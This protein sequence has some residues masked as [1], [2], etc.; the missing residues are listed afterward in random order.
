MKRLLLNYIVFILLISQVWG[1]DP[2]YSQFF[3]APQLL[4]PATTGSASSDWRIMSNYRQQWDNA[5]TPFSTFSLT[6]ETKL[7]GKEKGENT[8]GSS[9]TLMADRS[10]YGAFKSVY[11]SGAI[12]YHVQLAVKHR[13]G[14]GI[15]ASYGN[16]RID[17]SQLTFGTQFTSRGFDVSLPS[18][19]NSLAT[20]KPF[21]SLGAGL[22]YNFHTEYF[23]LDVGYSR[24]HL[25]KPLQSFIADPQQKIPLRYVAH[26]NMEYILSRSLLINVNVAYQKQATQQYYAA[27]GA[28]GL[29]ISG[30]DRNKIFFAGAWYRQEDAIY[31]Y[32][33][34][35]IGNV[36]MGVSYDVTVS[37]QNL[38]PS[39]PRTIELSMVVKKGQN[40]LGVIPCPWK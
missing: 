26:M 12:A 8:I 31:P 21:V 22:L 4:N 20:M 9:F 40:I 10:L 33:S 38:G 16:R 30:G 3:M 17:Y 32:I 29:D 36:Q 24:F 19:E 1:Q 14:L 18:G 25:N 34:L 6:M 23:N 28:L 15:H 35:L 7:A 27:G 11:A 37:K 5:E 39:N 2:H 13:L